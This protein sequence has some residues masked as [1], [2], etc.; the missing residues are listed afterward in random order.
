MVLIR[1]VTLTGKRPSIITGSEKK[2]KKMKE[3]YIPGVGMVP[4]EEPDHTTVEVNININIV[5]SEKEEAEMN[6]MFD[7]K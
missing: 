5:L 4:I 1:D 3:V 2:E 6:K 7:S